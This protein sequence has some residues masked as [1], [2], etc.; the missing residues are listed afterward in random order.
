MYGIREEARESGYHDPK[1]THNRRHDIGRNLKVAGGPHS[2]IR[3]RGTEVHS[4]CEPASWSST[5]E[6]RENAMTKPG[7][8]YPATCRTCTC[9]KLAPHDFDAEL[10]EQHGIPCAFN[11]TP[12]YVKHL[13]AQVVD[14]MFEEQYPHQIRIYTCRLSQSKLEPYRVQTRLDLRVSD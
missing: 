3:L 2:R 1:I 7:L 11:N 14:W 12:T 9:K 6:L 5:A 13:G 8:S 10:R 4:K